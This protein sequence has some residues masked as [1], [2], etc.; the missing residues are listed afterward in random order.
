[1]NYIQYPSFVTTIHGTARVR[2]DSNDDFVVLRATHDARNWIESA[3]PKRNQESLWFETP[4]SENKDFYFE[5]I[6][7]NEIKKKLYTDVMIRHRNRFSDN[8]LIKTG[9][10]FEL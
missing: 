2:F 3:K 8:N 4:S 7:G 6:C 1:M 10:R 9:R 5:V